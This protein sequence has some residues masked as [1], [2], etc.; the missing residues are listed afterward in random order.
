M[1]LGNFVRLLSLAAPVVLLA[2]CSD[3]PTNQG[4]GD[5]FAIVSNRAST[6]QG[7][8]SAFTVTA[9][10]VDR[11]GTSLPVQ[12]TATSSKVDVVAVDSFRYA[13]ELQETRFYLRTLKV[14]ASAP[15]VLTA[16]SLTDTVEVKVLSGPFPGTVNTAAFSGGTVLQF[17]STTNLFDA[18]T[19]V[20]VTTTEPGFLI[21]VTPTRVRYLLPFGTPAGP[22]PYAIT[23][24]GPADFS[25]SGNSNVPAIPCTDAFEPNNT[26]GA[27]NTTALT[28]GGSVYGGANL[29]TDV[30]DIFRFTV[31]EAGSYELRVDWSD[32]TD[33]DVY[34]LSAAGNLLSTAGGTAAKPEVATVT[35][36]PGNYFAVVEMYDDA[37]GACTTYK[38]TLT[39]K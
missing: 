6:I 20:A 34:P 4:S 28:V 18:N 25:L 35:M 37:G 16:A 19:A 29:T 14:D 32:G 7:V 5:A 39:K 24:A 38:L 27:A 17:T 21:D 11:A 12:V 15:V 23:G 3:D 26:L 13:P 1:K 22:I 36:A 9:R 33:V 8:G 2:A 10:V 31:T 30:D